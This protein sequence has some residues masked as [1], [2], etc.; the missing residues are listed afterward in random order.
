[1]S[2]DEILKMYRPTSKNKKPIELKDKQNTQ[3]NTS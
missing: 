2:V 3:Y 1:M